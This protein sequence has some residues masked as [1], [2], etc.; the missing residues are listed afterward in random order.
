MFG[1]FSRIGPT[2]SKLTFLLLTKS[3]PK[4][5]K[6]TDTEMGLIIGIIAGLII[7]FILTRRLINSKRRGRMALKLNRR[8]LV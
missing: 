5:E 7:G 4:A 2:I 8:D 6:G 1:C 3:I